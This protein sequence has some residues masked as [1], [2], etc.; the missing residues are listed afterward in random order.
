[1]WAA[2]VPA[3]LATL[4]RTTTVTTREGRVR[5]VV[6][7]WAIAT[8]AFFALVQTKF[9]HYILP[10]EPALGPIVA[11]W[12]DDCWAGRANVNLVFT[13]LGAGIVLVLARDMMFEEKQWIEMFI[14][15][16]DRPWPTAEPYAIDTTDAFLALGLMSAAAIV[17]HALARGRA[18]GA[19]ALAVAG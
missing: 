19:P 14:F 17:L 4:A 12:I 13:L 15:R 16:Y 7:V 6:G 10:A 8:V 11:F 9:H 1:M 2:V 3:A 5:F 18:I